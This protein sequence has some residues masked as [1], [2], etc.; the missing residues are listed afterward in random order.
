MLESRPKSVEGFRCVQ[1]PFRLGLHTESAELAF[2]TFSLLLQRRLGVHIESNILDRWLPSWGSEDR[3]CRRALQSW[4]PWWP[5]WKGL[6]VE[7]E[8]DRFSRLLHF[9]YQYWNSSSID[10]TVCFFLF[11]VFQPID[12]ILITEVNTCSRSALGI[13]TCLVERFL[14]SSVY[15]G[16]CVQRLKAHAR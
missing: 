6:R 7:G 11:K 2:E 3:E 15:I 13:R 4:T 14:T 5:A 1:R 16:N 12:I 10:R 8:A 9:D